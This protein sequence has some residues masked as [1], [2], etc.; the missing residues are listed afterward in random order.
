MSIVAYLVEI[1][2]SSL[3]QSLGEF[4]TTSKNLHFLMVNYFYLKYLYSFYWLISKTQHTEKNIKFKI[5]W[6]F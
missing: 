5:R 1:Q 6:D 3:L 2:Q 4:K